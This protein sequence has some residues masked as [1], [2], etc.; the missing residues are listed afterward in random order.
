MENDQVPVDNNHRDIP[1]LILY[2]PKVRYTCRSMYCIIKTVHGN[3]IATISYGYTS[4]SPGCSYVL[5][6]R[7]NG[8]T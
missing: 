2:F 4:E 7:G 6:G 5:I 3:C 1:T 8:G